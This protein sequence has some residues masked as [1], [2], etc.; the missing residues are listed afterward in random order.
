[1]GPEVHL[2]IPFHGTKRTL[3]IATKEV[4]IKLLSHLTQ[5]TFTTKALIQLDL[6]SRI[7]CLRDCTTNGSNCGQVG[8]HPM[9]IDF[10][11]EKQS[12]GYYKTDILDGFYG[13]NGEFNYIGLMKTATSLA[14]DE[15]LEILKQ[16]LKEWNLIPKIDTMKLEIDQLVTDYQDKMTF[17][18][19]LA[20]YVENIKKT[21]EALAGI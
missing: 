18:N 20:L 17:E 6:I 15:K 8:D 19:D 16:S 11:I 2:I 10:R 7:L 3:Y 1:M 9:I 4:S 13:G 5:E 21:V 12:N 14:R